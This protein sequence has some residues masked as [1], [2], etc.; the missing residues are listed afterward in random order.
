MRAHSDNC[1]KKNGPQYRCSCGAERSVSVMTQ[2]VL[3]LTFKDEDA[4]VYG[5]FPTWIDARD[6]LKNIVED[7]VEG[8]DYERCVVELNA[9][10]AD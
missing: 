6:Y 1:A 5:P 10:Q 4:S 9:P 8:R 3:V 7:M 2:Y